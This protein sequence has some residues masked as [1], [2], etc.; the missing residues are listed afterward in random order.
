MI[1]QFMM[2]LTLFILVDVTNI[3]EEH[4]LSFFLQ[5]IDCACGTICVNNQVDTLF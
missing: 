4:A 5:F 1:I 3:L 2:F